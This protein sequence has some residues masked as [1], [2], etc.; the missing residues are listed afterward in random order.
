MYQLVVDDSK[1]KATVI[2]EPRSDKEETESSVF[3]YLHYAAQPG[4]KSAV[5]YTPGMDICF[6][7]LHHAA[8]IQLQI[9]LT[10]IL[11]NIGGSSTLT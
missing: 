8:S 2:H 3:L 6:I 4:Y 1:V 10:Q 7:L 11:A 9:Y 5:V